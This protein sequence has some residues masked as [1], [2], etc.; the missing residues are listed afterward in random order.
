MQLLSSPEITEGEVKLA[1]DLAVANRYVVGWAWTKPSAWFCPGMETKGPL[2]CLE[3]ATKQKI[4]EAVREVLSEVGLPQPEEA[5]EIKRA[6]MEANSTKLAAKATPSILVV[7][8]WE[9]LHTRLDNAP[10]P[11]PEVLEKDIREV[12]EMAYVLRDQLLK[13]GRELPHRPGGA[14]PKLDSRAKKRACQL[15]GTMMGEG[16][17]LSDAIAKV[18][19]RFEVSEKTIRRAWQE[20]HRSKR[21]G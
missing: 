10:E 5:T 11:K 8:L 17:S 3:R 19:V 13:V 9:G 6:A 12:R 7:Q 1:I 2:P 18:A 20:L 16:D 21:K 15:I 14:K 4:L